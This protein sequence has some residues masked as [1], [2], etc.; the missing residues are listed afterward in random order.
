[1][2]INKTLKNIKTSKP[3]L[4]QVLLSAVII[5]VALVIFAIMMATKK[6]V[7]RQSH[8][9]AI[10]IVET[11]SVNTDSVTVR[12]AG[13]GTV[14]PLEQIF[15][16]PQV[17]GKI[18]Y[19]SD[20]FISGGQFTLGDTLLKIDPADYRLLLIS[21]RARV[22][23]L[24]SKLMIAKEESKIAIEEWKIKIGRAHV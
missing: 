8:T 20:S 18:I 7:K 6:N 21:A 3:I 1:M 19:I 2:S 4:F 24:E 9:M 22:K 23:D 10:P 13:E 17:G 11:I 14:K 12:I 16:S 5:V 15:L